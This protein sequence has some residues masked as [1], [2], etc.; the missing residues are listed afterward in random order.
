MQQYSIPSLLHIVS[1]DFIKNKLS[2][3]RKK[4]RQWKQEINARTNGINGKSADDDGDDGDD[5]EMQLGWLT[6]VK[7]VRPIRKI[8]TQS[9]ESYVG[10]GGKVCELV[11][12]GMSLLPLVTIV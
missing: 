2:Y 8:T 12:S 11:Y 3:K 5:N 1:I 4:R 6:L 10:F 7:R 9:F